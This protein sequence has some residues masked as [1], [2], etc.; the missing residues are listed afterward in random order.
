MKRIIRLTE[1]DLTKLIRRI[2]KENEEDWVD[3]SQDMEAESDFSK[4]DL[5]SIP[6]FQELVTFFQENPDIAQEIKSAM[7][8]N[9]TEAYKFY[10]YSDTTKKE[11]TRNQY[12]KRK[13]MNYGIW[14]TLGAIVGYMM[15][16]MAGDEV[17][18]AA[19]LM[20][21]MGGTVGAELSGQVGRERVKENRLYED[22]NE[23]EDWGETDEGD[24][25][26]QD[27]IEEARDFL[28][29]ECGYDLH[30]LN[31]MSEYDIVEA[32]YDE[33]NEELAEEIEELLNKEGFVDLDEPYDSIGGHSVNDLKKAFAKTKGRDEELGEG[34]DD[35]TQKK[36]YPKDYE[37]ENYMRLPKDIFKSG[38]KIDS[39]GTRL[40]KR[41]EDP[42]DEYQ[43]FDDEE[44][45]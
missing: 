41:R 43:D 44:F 4:M 16:T 35:F 11:I 3:M 36:R 9:V 19:L 30:D 6:E 22:D 8:S 18:Q 12:L 2:I 14:G 26:L 13:L 40:S 20:A 17:L 29:S 45:V 39:E 34:W 10:D 37:P 5:E 1:T 23:D 42:F 27:L 31:L 24:E 7:E 15:G 28:E 33:G 38:H 32:L 21:G 25:V